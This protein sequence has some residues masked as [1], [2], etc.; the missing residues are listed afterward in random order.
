MLLLLLGAIALPFLAGLCVL[1]LGPRL[2]ASLRR[3]V[4]LSVLLLTAGCVVAL[5]RYV[6]RDPG[7]AIA[8]LP[9][10]GRMTLDLGLSA[11]YVLLATD[12]AACLVALGGWTPDSQ[13]SHYADAL[14]LVA[15]AATGVALLSGHFLLR[16]AALEMAALCV[17]LAPLAE[18]REGHGTHLTFLVYLLL[19]V[20]D[21]GLLSAV[22]LLWGSFTTLEVEPALAAVSHLPRPA[23]QIAAAGLLTA[24]WAKIGA[25]PFQAWVRAGRRLTPRSEAWLYATV[26]PNLGLYLLYRVVRLL[27]PTGP[28]GSA[29]MWLGAGGAALAAFLALRQQDPDR[30]LPYVAAALGGLAV[31]A[32]SGGLQMVVW[33]SALVLTPARVLLHLALRVPQRDPARPLGAAIGAL[34]LGGWALCLTYWARGAGLPSAA[35]HLA[36]VGVALLAVWAIAVVWDALSALRSARLE[37]VPYVRWAGIGLLGV[38]SVALPWMLKPLFMSYLSYYGMPLEL[39][40]LPTFRSLLRYLWTM[41]ALWGVAALVVGLELW[42]VGLS[43]FRVKGPKEGDRASGSEAPDYGAADRVAEDRVAEDRVA[44]DREVEE[45]LVYIA[46]RVRDLIEQHV[47]EGTLHQAVRVA[48]RGSELVYRWME[49]GTLEAA[50][51]GVVR[52]VREL[53]QAGQRWHTGR[54]RRNLRWIVAS[55]VLAVGV[56]VF[57]V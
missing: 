21:A 16:Y 22:V 37:T 2:S 27:A 1:A 25:W 43:V 53:A 32:A 48:V 6:G 23:A 20:G 10:T 57:V 54:L 52:V 39:P 3:A 40:A 19:R 31:V 26:L 29:P 56:L 13:D 15:M 11:L 18:V 24:S 45:D 5:L 38:T 28:L 8:W 9:G 41:P 35:L 34:G 55:A 30:S 36:E 42:G 14:M 12:A 33:L 47:L 7:I 44:E 46:A 4:T 50:L 51:R 49:Q 17:A